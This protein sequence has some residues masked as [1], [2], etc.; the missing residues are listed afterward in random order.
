MYEG[1]VHGLTLLWFSFDMSGVAYTRWLY[2]L[3]IKSI[4]VQYYMTKYA[5]HMTIFWV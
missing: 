3:Q 1:E 4:I 2:L 5:L